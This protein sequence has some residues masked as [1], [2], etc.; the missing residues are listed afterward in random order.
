M[1]TAGRL[2]AQGA[3]LLT[4]RFHDH[5]RVFGLPRLLAH[6]M[7]AR[8]DVLN[9]IYDEIHATYGGLQVD[10]SAHP[11]V[12]DREFWSLDRL[13]PSELGTAPWPPSSPPSRAA[14]AGLPTA[15]P[16]AGHGDPTSRLEELRWLATDGVPWLA[17]RLRDL[18][19]VLTRT[20]LQ[21]LLPGPHP[22]PTQGGSQ[23]A[24]TR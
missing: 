23:P 11:G 20:A 3:M 5:T 7:G 18:G 19:P 4:V 8:I 2:G 13:H 9:A 21:N 10:L 12:Y 14:R 22:A 24:P 1:H 16:G 6:S 17:R 15:C